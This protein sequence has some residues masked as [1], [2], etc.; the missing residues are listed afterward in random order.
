M[1]KKSLKVIK[2]TNSGY[3]EQLV[4]TMTGRIVKTEEVIRQIKKGNPTYSDYIVVNGKSR[5]YVRSK[6]DNSSKNNIE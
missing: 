1:N 2:E 5:E 4:N 6:P 3:N